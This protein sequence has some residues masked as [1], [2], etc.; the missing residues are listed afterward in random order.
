MRSIFQIEQN[1]THLDMGWNNFSKRPNDEL[2]LALSHL[3]S[4]IK[5]VTLRGNS[6]GK[7]S[8]EDEA[9][10]FLALKYATHVDLSFNDLNIQKR[11]DIGLKGFASTQVTSLGFA[12]HITLFGKSH[13]DAMAA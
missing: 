9:L 6:L 8:G 7:K 1:T 11:L 12:E 5:L 13:S 4:Q 3:N 10:V 2:Q